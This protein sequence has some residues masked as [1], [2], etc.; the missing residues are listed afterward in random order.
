MARGAWQT[1]P[2]YYRCGP[3]PRGAASAGDGGTPS[4]R[5]TTAR[6][7]NKQRPHQRSAQQQ[8]PSSSPGESVRERRG[9]LRRGGEQVETGG[10]GN[11]TRG[12]GAGVGRTTTRG[13]GVRGGRGRGRARVSQ[14]VVSPELAR[15]RARKMLSRLRQGESLNP[16]KVGQVLA[17]CKDARTEESSGKGVCDECVLDRS[18][19]ARAFHLCVRFSFN[20]RCWAGCLPL[21]TVSISP[22]HSHSLTRT[23]P[24]FKLYFTQ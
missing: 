1:A 5:R 14:K 17:E 7:G 13:R 15:S 22:S 16:R 19:N 9:E 20:N 21:R 24:F 23:P 8:P 4:R 6:R 11:K 3:P 10:A 2:P 18:H 12:G